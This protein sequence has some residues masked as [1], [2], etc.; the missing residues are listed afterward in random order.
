MIITSHSLLIFP[1]SLCFPEGQTGLA[2]LGSGQAGRAEVMRE[3]C[4]GDPWAPGRREAGRLGEV[5]VESNADGVMTVP[6]D[7]G[8]LGMQDFSAQTWEVPGK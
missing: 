8:Y 4:T 6:V 3:I 1:P 7:A 2:C 5:R